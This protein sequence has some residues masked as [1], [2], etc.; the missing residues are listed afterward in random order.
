M[1]ENNFVEIRAF[2]GK[3][4]IDSFTK[5]HKSHWDVTLKA[6]VGQLERI[7]AFLLT[8][9]AEIISDVGGVKLI[10]TKFKIAASM[11]SAKTSGNRCIVA[12]YS[13]KR[14]VSILLVYSKTDLSGQN[15]TDKWKKIIRDNYP[16]YEGHCK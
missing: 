14:K 2:A 5:K 16:E 8:D 9:K 7:E 10:K 1:P 15:E 12:W 13:D 3:H 11:E 4:Y 6:I